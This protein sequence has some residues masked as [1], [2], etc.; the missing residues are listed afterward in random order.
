[1]V[2][3]SVFALFHVFQLGEHKGNPAAHVL[4][5]GKHKKAPFHTGLYPSCSDLEKTRKILPQASTCSDLVKNT[6]K[7]LSLPRPHHHQLYS[8]TDEEKSPRDHLHELILVRNQTFRIRN[9]NGFWLEMQKISMH[10]PF[11]L[12]CTCTGGVL[13]PSS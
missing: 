9:Q 13:F 11:P 10:A 5:W 1:M 4:I 8:Q 12:H 7:P 3:L 2:S 6:R